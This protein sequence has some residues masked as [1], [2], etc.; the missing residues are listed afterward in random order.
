MVELARRDQN[1]VQQLLNLRVTS[2]GLIK[3]LVDEVDRTLHLIGVFDFLTLNDD[4]CANDARSGGDVD[5]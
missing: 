1:G 2:F 5:Q 4:S 3:N